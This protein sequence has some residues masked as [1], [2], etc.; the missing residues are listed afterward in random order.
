LDSRLDRAIDR[1]VRDMMHVDPRAGFRRRV[2]ARLEP[3]PMRSSPLFFRI[4]GA[5]ALA[6]L[7]LTVLVLRYGGSTVDVDR[8]RPAADSGATQA[9]QPVKP[10]L[11]AARATPPP[12]QAVRERSQSPRR[13]THEPIPMP[14]VANVFGDRQN[15]VA[16]TA[17]DTDTLWPAN[18][19]AAPRENHPDAPP[20]LV[21]PPLEPAAPIVIPPLNPRGPGD[22]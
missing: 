14:R 13:T 6:V 2:Q 20:P 21:I 19:A 4:A 9:R 8:A 11:D 15:G 10:Q 7:V 17:V 22:L 18:A 1:A 5:G 16:A 12:S 3:Q